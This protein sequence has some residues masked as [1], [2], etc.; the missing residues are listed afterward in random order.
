MRRL[1]ALLGAAGVA[2][3]LVRRSRAARDDRDVWTRAT[4]APDLR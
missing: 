1:I 3:A 2:A 4:E